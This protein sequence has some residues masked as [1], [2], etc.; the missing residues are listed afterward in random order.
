[1]TDWR[2]GALFGLLKERVEEMSEELK[3]AVLRLPPATRAVLI[4]VRN[5]ASTLDEVDAALY[6]AI[7]EKLGLDPGRVGKLWHR[8]TEY[9]V[10]QVWP[11]P[12]LQ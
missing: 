4:E 5:R 12:R 3:S 8:A 6:Q 2:E 9:L 1:M 7:G 10:K 11:T